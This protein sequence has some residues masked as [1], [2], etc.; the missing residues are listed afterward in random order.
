MK[1]TTLVVAFV[2]LATAALAH[3]DRILSVGVDGAIPELP[4]AYQTTRLHIAFSEGDAGALQQLNFLSSGQET[5]VPPCLLRLVPKSSLRQLFLS[6]SWYHDV[7]TLPH[8]LVVEFRDSPSR[9]GVPDYPGVRFLFSLRDASLLEVT[10]VVA[11][12]AQNVVQDRTVR[13]SNGCPV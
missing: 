3:Q 11:L 2:V 4:P 12:P 7:S 1:R 13:L 10:Q 9:Q 6:G 8:Y 5:S